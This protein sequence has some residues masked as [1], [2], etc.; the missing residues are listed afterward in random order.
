MY[1]WKNGGGESQK[2]YKINTREYNKHTKYP[3]INYGSGKTD[4]PTPATLNIDR[5]IKFS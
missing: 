3:M 4:T 2:I 1:D 5:F